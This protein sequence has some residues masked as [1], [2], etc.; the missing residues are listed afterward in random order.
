[1]K[2]EH[3]PFIYAV[4]TIAKVT[5][6]SSCLASAH[7]FPLTCTLAAAPLLAVAVSLC[8]R[9]LKGLVTYRITLTVH[10]EKLPIWC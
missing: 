3:L 5:R 10:P 8:G 6:K 9:E 7:C 1:M 4:V 2:R